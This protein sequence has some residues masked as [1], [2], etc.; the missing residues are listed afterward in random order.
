MEDK[1]A[2]W[3]RRKRGATG[4]GGR[5]RRSEVEEGRD[6]GGMREEEDEGV[7]GKVRAAGRKRVEGKARI[8]KNRGYNGCC[9]PPTAVIAVEN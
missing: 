9:G 7:R 5:G 3:R 6:D 2:R 4:G 1:A 8:W